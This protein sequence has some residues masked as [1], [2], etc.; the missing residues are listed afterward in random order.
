VMRARV[1]ARWVDLMEFLAF[2][3]VWS[4]GSVGEADRGTST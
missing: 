4:W 1:Y 2:C 3:V